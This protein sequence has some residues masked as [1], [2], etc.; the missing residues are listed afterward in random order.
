MSAKWIGFTVL[1]WV[2][3]MFLGA[4]F[5]QHTTGAGTWEGVT[6]ET[7]LEYLMNVKHI[8]HQED[9]VGELHFVFINT[10]YFATAWQ[11]ISWDFTFIRGEWYEIVRWVV[12]IPF[13]IAVAF[14]FLY[15]FITLLQGF[16]HL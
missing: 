7:T 5:E 16:L 6:Q 2:V 8:T 14:G 10:E 1:I 12:L 11:I 9:A 4:T 13:S 3:C 15:M